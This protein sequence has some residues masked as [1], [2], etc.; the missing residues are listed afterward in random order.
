M[1]GL[2]SHH[3]EHFRAKRA[4]RNIEV[5]FLIAHASDQLQSLDL[6]TFAMMK[7]TF[8]A[9]KV[10]RLMN[11]QSNAV[12]RMLSAWFAASAPHHNVEAY[13]SMGLI[14]VER[15]SCFFLAVY[16]ENA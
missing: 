11:L 14:P 1:D 4:A 13:M 3:T 15:D 8:S 9:S 6:L 12:I 7:Q 16:P 5:L 2:G 10:N